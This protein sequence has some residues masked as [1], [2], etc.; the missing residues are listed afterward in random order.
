MTWILQKGARYDL[1]IDSIA[2]YLSKVGLRIKAFTANQAERAARLWSA[3]QGLGLSL[4]DRACLAL[5]QEREAP[6]PTAGRSWTGQP[7][8]VEVRVIR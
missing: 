1:P 5:A 6:A 8:G 3:T 4:A 2:A 7:L